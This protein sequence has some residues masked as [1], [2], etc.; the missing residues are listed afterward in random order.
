MLLPEIHVDGENIGTRFEMPVLG[1]GV[2]YSALDKHAACRL[3]WDCGSS[4]A[5]LLSAS[6]QSNGVVQEF[7]FGHCEI[8]P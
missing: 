8:A 4:W 3:D 7:W 2:K 5:P 1:L 6:A